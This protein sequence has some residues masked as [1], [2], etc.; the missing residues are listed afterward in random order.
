MAN[1]SNAPTNVRVYP[2]PSTGVEVHAVF[3]QSNSLPAT[4]ARFQV[5]TDANFTSI[6]YDSN[7]VS[8][9]P[10]NDNTE[11]VMIFSWI[12]SSTGTYYYRL[13]FWDNANYLHTSWT[14]WNGATYT[15]STSYNLLTTI[16]PASDVSIQLT[17]VPSGTHYTTIDETTA[18]DTDYVTYPNGG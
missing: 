4:Y 10:I 15:T 6:I 9:T 18:D 17:A 12:P 2:I 11:G 1:V 7:Q 14:I 13:C 5:A 3:H 16:R 8:I